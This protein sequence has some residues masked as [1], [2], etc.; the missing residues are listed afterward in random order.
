MWSTRP[1]KVLDSLSR[2][3]TPVRPLPEAAR[4]THDAARD[5]IVHTL[6]Y[7]SRSDTVVESVL[8]AVRLPNR[9]SHAKRA[10]KTVVRGSQLAVRSSLFPVRDG[11]LRAHR[12]GGRF[13]HLQG[14][15]STSSQHRRRRDAAHERWHGTHVRHRHVVV[16]FSVSSGRSLEVLS[17]YCPKRDDRSFLTGSKATF[18]KKTCPTVVGFKAGIG[19]TCHQHFGVGSIQGA[20]TPSM[21]AVLRACVPHGRISQD[22]RGAC[23]RV[24]FV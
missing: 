11:S 3:P 7:D 8:P 22:V 1:S 14:R 23:V 20:P 9:P 17:L 10:W 21:A 4:N 16:G 5:P 24:D 2:R 19:T 13:S 12:L 15:P 6:T 18:E